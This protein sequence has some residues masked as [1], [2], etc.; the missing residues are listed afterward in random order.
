MMNN[1]GYRRALAS[2]VCKIESEMYNLKLI[3]G[4]YNIMIY[5]LWNNI[6][7]EINFNRIIYAVSIYFN[8]LNSNSHF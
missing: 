1:A 5:F 3:L 2:Q 7:I 8:S 4:A 6:L